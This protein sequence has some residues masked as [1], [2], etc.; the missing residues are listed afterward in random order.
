MAQKNFLILLMLTFA[1]G[2]LLGCKDKCITSS[3]CGI[4]LHPT[5]SIKCLFIDTI[6]IYKNSMSLWLFQI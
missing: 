1:F 6:M 2:L 4:K 5:D 3:E